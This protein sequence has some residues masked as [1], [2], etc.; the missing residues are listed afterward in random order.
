MHRAK[1]KLELGIAMFAIP[2]PLLYK[3]IDELNVHIDLQKSFKNSEE[4]EEFNFDLNSVEN[5][6]E[7]LG[8]LR[9]LGKRHV[10]PIIRTTQGPP[11]K[12]RN[13]AQKS[14]QKSLSFDVFVDQSPAPTVTQK[15]I[16][17][18]TPAARQRLI[19]DFKD[20]PDYQ[21]S[22]LYIFFFKVLK[23]SNK[24]FFISL[25]TFWLF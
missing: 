15:I 5:C 11:G 9:G 7:T 8:K 4:D 17:N 10:A 19:D 18:G 21:V 20:D 6:R 3:A 14:A 16:V 23:T 1:E 2:L 12:V 25:G 22:L 24:N 13:S